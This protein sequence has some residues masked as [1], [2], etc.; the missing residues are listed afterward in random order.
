MRAR[1][2]VWK[3]RRVRLSVSSVP[4]T[5]FD[6]EGTE[7]QAVAESIRQ[8]EDFFARIDYV[9]L[10]AP[11]RILDRVFD[12]VGFQAIDDTTMFSAASSSHGWLFRSASE[13][14]WGDCSRI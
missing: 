9:L 2:L 4:T 3:S 12:L 13:P 6:F 7:A 5:E 8:A 1:L 14:R 10:N 11:K